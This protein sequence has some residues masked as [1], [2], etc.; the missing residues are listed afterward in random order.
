MSKQL[1][2]T[3]SALHANGKVKSGTFRTRTQC[4]NKIAWRIKTLCP[5]FRTGSYATRTA[6]RVRQRQS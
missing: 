3:Y 2:V 5:G 1:V 4:P 6:S